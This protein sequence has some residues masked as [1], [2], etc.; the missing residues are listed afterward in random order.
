M[1]A[2]HSARL[3][4]HRCPPARHISSKLSILDHFVRCRA[5]GPHGAGRDDLLPE[6]PE[7]LD[8]PGLLLRTESRRIARTAGDGSMVLLRDQ[9]RERWHHAL[10]AEG[11]AIVREGLRRRQPGPYQIQVAINAACPR[12]GRATIWR[13]R[14]C[15]GRRKGSARGSGHDLVDRRAPGQPAGV[16]RARRFAHEWSSSTAEPTHAGGGV[17]PHADRVDASERRWRNP[18]ASAPTLVP[19][20]RPRRERSVTSGDAASSPDGVDAVLVETPLTDGP[21]APDETDRERMEEP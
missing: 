4:L 14:R 1:R 20:A 21:D 13:L 18:A 12:C 16:A 7:V 11:Q 10:V 8:L 5:D 19:S 9:D 2:R 3:V 6:E 15:G 17:V